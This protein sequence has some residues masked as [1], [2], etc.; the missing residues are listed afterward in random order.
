MYRAN[1][2]QARRRKGLT[3]P[4]GRQP[5][6]SFFPLANGGDAAI[7]FCFVFLYLAFAGGGWW[8]L[9][10]AALHQPLRPRAPN[11]S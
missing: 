10:R 5:P 1:R 2:E 8:S 6:R 11:A 9:D 3:E 7:L 4:P